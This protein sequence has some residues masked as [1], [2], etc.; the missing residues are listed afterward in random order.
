[1]RSAAAH[2]IKNC[3]IKKDACVG[4]FFDAFG[5]SGRGRGLPIVPHS[6]RRRRKRAYIQGAKACFGVVLGKVRA[7]GALTQRVSAAECCTVQSASVPCA[8]RDAVGCFG[9]CVLHG[10]VWWR[11]LPPAPRSSALWHGPPMPR[12]GAGVVFEFSSQGVSIP[13]FEL[14]VRTHT[15]G[16]CSLFVHLHLN[17][18]CNPCPCRSSRH[19]DESF[20]FSP[21]PPLTRSPSP[22]RAGEAEMAGYSLPPSLRGKWRAQRAER[23]TLVF[24]TFLPVPR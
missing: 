12:R 16:A 22:A 3:S 1:M 2:R 9:H 5:C 6:R 15:E 20:P 7:D 13:C 4:V 8:F 10:E 11:S 18:E 24:S 21:P 17:R 19:L 14:C 23:G